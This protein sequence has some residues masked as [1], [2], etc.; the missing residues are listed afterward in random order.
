[1]PLSRE[2]A[3]DAPSWQQR[4]P[5][6]D[7]LGQEC[8]SGAGQV[9]RV[10][11]LHGWKGV[12]WGPARAGGPRY[13][14]SWLRAPTLSRE[15]FPWVS[16]EAWKRRCPGWD[17]LWDTSLPA[18]EAPL[19]ALQLTRQADRC[20]TSGD[21]KHSGDV[22]KTG[23]AGNPANM[24]VTVRGARWGLDVWGAHLRSYRNV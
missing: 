16:M 9:A 6:P 18:A 3:C 11:Q 21:A 4:A 20:T 19:P 7:K 22:F 8:P 24:V 2:G 15:T 17:R 13:G 5:L 14:P 1:M 10:P 23:H 12:S